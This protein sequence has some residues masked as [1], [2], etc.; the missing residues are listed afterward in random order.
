MEVSYYNI[1]PHHYSELLGGQY[2]ESTLFPQRAKRQAL[3]TFQKDNAQFG[4]Y[5]P[6]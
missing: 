6:D 3:K 4:Q 1:F 2:A 5:I